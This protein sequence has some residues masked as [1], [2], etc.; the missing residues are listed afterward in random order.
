MALADGTSGVCVCIKVKGEP[1]KCFILNAEV[2]HSFQNVLI[3]LSSSTKTAERTSS[4]LRRFSSIYHTIV[5]QRMIFS[6]V[7]TALIRVNRFTF[8]PTTVATVKSSRLV[9]NGHIIIPL[10]IELNMAT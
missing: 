4:R 9:T 8:V 10:N 5:E 3:R 7:E 6:K 1:W 2:G